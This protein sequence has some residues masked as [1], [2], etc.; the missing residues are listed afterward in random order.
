[1]RGRCLAVAMILAAITI[2][3]MTVSAEPVRA[4]RLPGYYEF[5]MKA[6]KLTRIA[7]EEARDEQISTGQLVPVRVIKALPDVSLPLPSGDPLDLRSYAGKQNLVLVSFR[8]WW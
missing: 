1:M 6:G 7:P 8:S 2:S 5:F 4:D 3:P